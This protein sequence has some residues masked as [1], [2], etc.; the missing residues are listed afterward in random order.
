MS[1]GVLSV[2]VGPDDHAI[3]PEGAPITLVEYGDYQCPYCGQAHPVV[4]ALRREFGD[5]LRFVFR[6]LPLGNVHPHAVHAAETAEAVALQ[7]LFWPMHD[8]LFENQRDLSDPALLTYARQTGADTEA[9]AQLLSRHGTSERI[10]N[11]VESALRSGANGTPTFFVNGRR[12]D[13]SWD[14]ETFTAYLR[15]LPA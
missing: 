15:A 9:V 1:E 7:G 13:K 11:D 12:Y 8:T 14:L 3:G 10:Q 4:Q 6:N 2:P 5:D